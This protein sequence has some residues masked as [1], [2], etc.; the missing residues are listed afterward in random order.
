M[1]DKPVFLVLTSEGG[2]RKGRFGRRCD[3]VSP[4]PGGDGPSPSRTQ[5]PC[6]NRA[7]GDRLRQDLLGAYGE[8]Q[9]GG[10]SLSALHRPPVPHPLAH[11]TG[12]RKA[13]LLTFNVKFSVPWIGGDRESLPTSPGQA[14]AGIQTLDTPRT[15]QSWAETHCLS[16][17]WGKLPSRE[18]TR[19]DL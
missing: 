5:E 9:R 15:G 12:G 18:V 19:L 6:C 13:R 8:L 11:K 2:F 3:L 7:D 1:E 16:S 14:A 17:T 10:G 4:S